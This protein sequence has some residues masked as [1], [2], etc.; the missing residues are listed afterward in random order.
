MNVRRFQFASNVGCKMRFRRIKPNARKTAIGA[1]PFRFR[2]WNQDIINPQA[3]AISIHKSSFRF[4]HILGKVPA[5]IALHPSSP[6]GQV[7]FVVFSRFPYKLLIMFPTLLILVF[8][9]TS[10]KIFCSFGTC[11]RTM[12]IRASK[13]P[14]QSPK[15][16]F[17]NLTKRRNLM[18]FHKN[19]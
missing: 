13:F 4:V 18:F 15:H 5:F 16:T 3:H 8:A 7:L 11:S 6:G 12:V 14:A 17:V 10:S 9:N 1:P 2:I 19:P